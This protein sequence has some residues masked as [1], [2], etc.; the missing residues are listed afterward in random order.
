MVAHVAANWHSGLPAAPNDFPVSPKLALSSD[1]AGYLRERIAH[2]A[3]GTLFEHLVTRTKA[4]E[5]NEVEF[6]WM[7]P[8][9]LQFSDR[10]RQQLV[11]AGNF[12][13]MI[14]GANL[15]YNLL[16]SE[17]TKNSERIDH[18]RSEL[19]QWAREIEQRMS[20]LQI[21]G[22]AAF[23]SCVVAEGARI[24]PQSRAFVEQWW[25]F[26]LNEGLSASI[27]DEK[28]PRALI[29]NRERQL[30][31]ALAR[32]DNPRARE[33]W[34]GASGTLR[35]AYRWSNAQR[36]TCDILEALESSNA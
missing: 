31:R 1:E 15:L 6:P 9:F 24:S 34:G 27:A 36:I 16:L 7:H 19:D 29:A 2:H 21:W 11:H 14:H 12:S 20:D 33:L 23:W 26:V 32:I 13:E 18:Y 30:K 8:R 25:D 4:K 17:L 5:G 22:K 10:I 3:P 35:L 28:A